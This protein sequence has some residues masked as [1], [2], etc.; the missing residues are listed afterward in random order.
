MTNEF[1]QRMRHEAKEAEIEEYNYR[2][3]WNNHFEF[4]PGCPR[5]EFYAAREAASL[6]KAADGFGGIRE[7]L[8]RIEARLGLK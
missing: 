7:D 3:H 2:I 1:T 8:K 4:E 5:C 6:K